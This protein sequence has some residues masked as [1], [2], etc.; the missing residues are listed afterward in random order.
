SFF[1][2]DCHN[3][4]IRQIRAAAKNVDCV[5][6]ALRDCGELSAF[7]MPLLRIMASYTA[8]YEVVTLI[9]S[10]SGYRDGECK[11]A[12]LNL[13]SRL[14]HRAGKLYVSECKHI[15]CIDLAAGMVTTI[16]AKL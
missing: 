5:V 7:A 8:E 6:A 10:E 13:P 1:V 11:Q 16:T 3:H 14:V 12:L 2:A 4:R 9:G 15:R